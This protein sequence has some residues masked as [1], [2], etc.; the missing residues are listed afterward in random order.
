MTT[1]IDATFGALADPTRRR[2]VELLRLRAHS[3][4][5]LAKRTGSSASMMSRH[6]RVLYE[7]GLVAEKRDD[8]DA[9]R[10]VFHLQRQ[11]FN[12]MQAW[13]DEMQTFWNTQLDS[14]KRHTAAPSERRRTP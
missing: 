4:G 3:S 10:R 14:F 9:R 13:L 1:K 8:R 11:P 6:L 5:E 12:A 2:A 7:S